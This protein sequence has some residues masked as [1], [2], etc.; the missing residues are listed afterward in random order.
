[1]IKL[2]QITVDWRWNYFWPQDLSLSCQMKKF[3]VFSNPNTCF[4]ILISLVNILSIV[5]IWFWYKWDL[6]GD[7]LLGIF[8]KNVI[9]Y[10]VF[11]FYWD[12][13]AIESPIKRRI[14]VQ[15]NYSIFHCQCYPLKAPAWEFHEM[16]FFSPKINHRQLLLILRERQCFIIGILFSVSIFELI[17]FQK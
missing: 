7:G 12:M 9:F 2:H 17:S 15:L 6:L 10:Q 14:I 4:W 13:R 8:S 16:R 11:Q 5:E 1:M 3:Q